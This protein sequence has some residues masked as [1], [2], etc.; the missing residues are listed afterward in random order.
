M[1]SHVAVHQA[2]KILRVTFS[3]FLLLDVIREIHDP[4]DVKREFFARLLRLGDGTP[5]YPD[6]VDDGYPEWIDRMLT[7]TFEIR[8]TSTGSYLL[9]EQG[10]RVWDRCRK[11]LILDKTTPTL[12]HLLA[13]MEAS[14]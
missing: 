2:R 1:S 5:T 8:T 9:T 6:D 12:K 4:S 3:T 10:W 7:V 13:R 14:N 11:D